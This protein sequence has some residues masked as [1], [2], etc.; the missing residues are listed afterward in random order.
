MSSKAGMLGAAQAIGAFGALNPERPSMPR[1]GERVPEDAATETADINPES[2]NRSEMVARVA[3]VAAAGIAAAA[4]EATLLPGV[5]PGIAAIWVPRHLPRIGI[6]LNQLFRNTMRGTYKIGHNA[7]EI[8]AEVLEQVRDMITEVE[9][10][11]NLNLKTS[12]SAG[13]ANEGVS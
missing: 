1:G 12:K 8:V 4:F 2:E 3:T 10:E 9:A 11:C 7:R 6:A 5:V 13:S